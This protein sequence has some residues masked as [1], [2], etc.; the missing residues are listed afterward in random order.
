MDLSAEKISEYREKVTERASKAADQVSHIPRGRTMPDLEQMTISE[1]KE[2]GM[3]VVFVDIV[4]SGKYLTD[5]GPRK[6]M[7][8]LNVF[9]P[10]VMDLVND[11][12][13]HFEKNTGDG[14]LAYFG[15]EKTERSAVEDLLEY[16]ACLRYVVDEIV[17]PELQEYN[18]PP[19]S[20]SVG[21]AYAQDVYLSRIGVWGQ[22]RLTAVSTAANV[23]FEL[24]ERAGADE[25][26]VDEGIRTFADSEDGWGQHLEKEGVL[27]GFRWGSS[28][29]GRH[30]SRYYSFIGGFEQSRSD[31][32]D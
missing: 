9:I 17:N 21:A 31:E 29:E 20:I 19:I 8:M 1:T 15:V 2:F 23:A 4:Q 14:V 10:Q 26:L 28:E 25:Y 24:Q 22:N 11:F 13:G 32:N 27:R 5:N 12:D 30:T 18:V 6:T 3:G 16:F 7:L